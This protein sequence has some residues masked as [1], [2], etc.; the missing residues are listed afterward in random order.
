MI[1]VSLTRRES[2]LFLLLVLVFFQTL[3][4]F[5]AFE[6]LKMGTSFMMKAWILRPTTLLKR[7]SNKGVA[8]FAKFLRKPFFIEHF[9]WLLLENGDSQATMRWLLRWDIFHFF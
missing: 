2:S 5:L 9:W 1:D 7:D 6:F 4:W 8:T 3:V